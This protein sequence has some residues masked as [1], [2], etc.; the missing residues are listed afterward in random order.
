M[1]ILK[2]Y[3]KGNMDKYRSLKYSEFGT[4][5]L[6]EKKE[7][8]QYNQVNSRLTDVE[9]FAKLLVSAPGLKFQGNQALLQQA[10]TGDKL[11]KAAAGGFKSLAKAVVKQA[12]K[13][14][15][16][17]AAKTASILAQVPVNG[18]GTHFLINIS[19]DTYLQGGTE[20]TTGLGRFLRDQGIGG[21]VNGAKSALNGEKIG[22]PILDS[23]GVRADTVLFGNEKETLLSR[24]QTLGASKATEAFEELS[25]FKLPNI[26]SL[27]TPKV[28]PIQ[29]GASKLPPLNKNLLGNNVNPQVPNLS[30]DYTEYLG[31]EI[32][33]GAGVGKNKSAPFG[34]KVDTTVAKDRKQ[35]QN[36]LESQGTETTNV[37]PNTVPFEDTKDKI[38]YKS[39][40]DGISYVDSPLNIQKKYRLGDQGNKN[41]AEK[42]VD[43]INQL[44]VQQESILNDDDK[45]DIIPFE[46]NIFEPGR[47]RFLYFR[48][49]LDSLNDNY[50]GDW[51][52]T[53]YIG[54]AE[55]F[56]TY[57]G[58]DRKIDFSFKMAALSKEELLPLYQK[59][60]FLVGVTAPTYAS[61]GEFMKG[62]MCA[63]TIGDYIS[64]QDGII[65]SVSVAWN[66]TYPWEIN[67]NAGRDGLKPRL[68]HMLDIS[69][70]FTP[71]HSF[72]VKS[73]LD[74]ENNETYIG[75]TRMKK[76]G[77]PSVEVGQGAFGGPFDQGDFVDINTVG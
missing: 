9:R 57:Q 63:L 7:G 4:G 42:G 43:F 41:S 34:N 18:T 15:T 21:G 53:K 5:P 65:T 61:N 48:A 64:R 1:G 60:N 56:Y 70:S 73:N 23:G 77:T 11:R 71:I 29:L 33:T 58:F 69:I 47:E 19:P 30:N 38:T 74:L 2:D 32:V 27:S 68:P 76:F 40:Q 67:N 35:M 16:N 8:F 3:D 6:I 10:D 49:F 39:A 72:N 26:S 62:T 22:S 51:S 45:K 55:Q 31:K 66:K 12:I 14:V 13:T 75:G 36:R 37:D 28:N 24:Q 54:R 59:L 52:G 50:T 17:N 25:N 46:F 44:S 20:P